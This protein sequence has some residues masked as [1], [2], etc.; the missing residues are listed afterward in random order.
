VTRVGFEDYSSVFRNCGVDGDMLLQLSDQDIKED[1]GITNGILRKRFM[2]ELH[3]LKK[4]ADY[5]SCDGGLIANFL[6]KISSE[7][8][9]Y[10]Y[11]LILKELTLDFLRRLNDQDLEDMLQDAGVSSAIHRH[12][13]VDAVMGPDEEDP[14]VDSFYAEPPID[15]Y[16]SYPVGDIQRKRQGAADLAS[17]VKMQLQR[18][19][20]SVFS[21]PHDN[22]PLTDRVLTQVRDSRYYLLV[23]PQGGLDSCLQDTLGS[24]RLHTEIAAALAA[25]TKIIPVT[26]DF[27]WPAP[28][29]LPEDIRGLA[30]FNGVRWV[31]DYQDASID[32][33]ER[34]IRGESLPRAESPFSVRSGYTRSRGDSGRSTPSHLSPLLLHNHLRQR[35]TSIDSALGSQSLA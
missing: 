15:V 24:D 28:E 30:Y 21:E 3:N 23:L 19:N 8:R 25:E 13:I 9:V 11:S 7:F 27:Q 1:I 33:I 12:K 31:H 26:V 32:K 17:L 4:N 5:T 20:L 18:R 10:T 2:R 16:L 35:K 22:S 34:F 29:E 6:N 14:F